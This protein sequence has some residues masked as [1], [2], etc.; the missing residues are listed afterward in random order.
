MTRSNQRTPLRASWTPATPRGSWGPRTH[1]GRRVPRADRSGR[2]VH[3][4]AHTAAQQESDRVR[5]AP[6]PRRPLSSFRAI[7]L[8]LD[9]CPLL[10]SSGAPLSRFVAALLAGGGS[11]SQRAGRALRLYAFAYAP[12]GAVAPRGSGF[13]SAWRV[14]C[15]PP[16]LAAHPAPQAR[17]DPERTLS[18]SLSPPDRGTT[19][20]PRRPHPRYRTARDHGPSDHGRAGP[21]PAG[22]PGGEGGVSAAPAAGGVHNVRGRPN[23]QPVL[24]LMLRSP[25]RRPVDSPFITPTFPARC[26]QGARLQAR[27]LLTTPNLRTHSERETDRGSWWGWTAAATR[28]QPSSPSAPRARA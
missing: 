7:A 3:A 2:P 13:S 8:V 26:Q 15:A 6:S 19:R 4:H 10:A 20:R 1:P 14:G 18:A 28:R 9:H 24:Y 16:P 25:S 22:R 27:S 11:A 17:P 5:S 23:P 21:T 12:L